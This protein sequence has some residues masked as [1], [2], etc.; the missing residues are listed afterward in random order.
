MY[1]SG[2]NYKTHIDKTGKTMIWGFDDVDVPDMTNGDEKYDSEHEW[3]EHVEIPK[4]S[5]K[6]PFYLSKNTKLFYIE[7]TPI[8]LAILGKAQTAE[9]LQLQLLAPYILANHG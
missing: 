9:Q 5:Y 6:T 4:D 1:K 8:A 7:L 2:T 3:A